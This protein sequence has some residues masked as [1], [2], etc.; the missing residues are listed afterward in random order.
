MS[1]IHKLSVLEPQKYHRVVHLLGDGDTNP[2]QI[3]VKVL[4]GTYSPR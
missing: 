1:K 2:C 3:K 4:L